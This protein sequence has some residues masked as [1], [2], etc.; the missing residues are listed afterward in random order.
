MSQK[1]LLIDITKCVG[2]R[3]CED[4]CKKQNN[5]PFTGEE[6]L[7]AATYTI[8]EEHQD[9][10]VRRLCMHC[11]HPACESVC[12]V[13]TFTKTDTGAVVYDGSK[14]IGC[15]Y[16]M[17]A[18]PF[19]IPKFEWN[20]TSPNVRK[21]DFCYSRIKKEQLPACVLACPFDV[22][23]FGN[24]DEVLEQARKIISENHTVYVNHIYGEQEVGGTS[25]LYISDVPFEDLGFKTK[26]EKYPLPELTWN[27]ISK[28]PSVVLIGGPLL[29]GIWW[30]TK[31]RKEV[32][33][34]N[35][36]KNQ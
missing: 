2:C 20:S 27:A 30:I 26:I 28:I 8:I 22:M 13:G 18:C 10:N 23:V 19:Q 35:I 33:G 36:Q 15:R 17:L 34:T 12:L 29:Y 11:K 32:E 5:L 1:A 9:R 6:K 31:R 25:I 16:C 3:Q 14:C 24:Y 21:C 4:A 7:S